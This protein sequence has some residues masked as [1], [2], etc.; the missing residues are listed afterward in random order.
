MRLEC[1]DKSPAQGNFHSNDKLEIAVHS[2][3]AVMLTLFDR[4]ITISIGC[5][6]AWIMIPGRARRD[7][8]KDSV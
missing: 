7:Q 6:S 5:R 4:S 8:E 2:D 3:T 1:S